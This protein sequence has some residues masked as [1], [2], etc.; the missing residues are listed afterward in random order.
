MIPID[1]LRYAH[2]GGGGGGD[3]DHGLYAHIVCIFFSF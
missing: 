3:D 2:G 1:I